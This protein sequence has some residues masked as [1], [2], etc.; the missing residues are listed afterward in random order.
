[1]NLDVAPDESGSVVDHHALESGDEVPG[2][3]ED[4]PCVVALGHLVEELD[5]VGEVHV[6]VEDDVA[7]RL[8]EGHGHEEV[9]VRRDH[10]PAGPDRLPH[11]VY[12]VVGELALE[13]QQEPSGEEE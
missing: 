2:H 12:L 10:L 5:D 3:L 8:D 9:E 6:P 4:L 1:M 11:Q 13:V 7:V